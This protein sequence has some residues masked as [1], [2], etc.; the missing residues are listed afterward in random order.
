MKPLM[1]GFATA[2]MFT[3]LVQRGASQ[4]APQPDQLH[5]QISTPQGNRISMT[6]LSMQRDVSR[7][8]DNAVIHLKGHVEIKTVVCIPVAGADAKV[9]EEAMVLRADEAEYHQDT[10]E[11]EARGNVRI[12]PR[13]APGKQ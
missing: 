3:A 10:G 12:I 9:C 7:T 4:A 13:A 11:I 2:L 5:T 8:A 6:A 1:F